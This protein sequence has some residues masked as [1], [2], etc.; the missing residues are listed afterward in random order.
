M[1]LTWEDFD[2]KLVFALRL[3]LFYLDSRQVVK[4]H[5]WTVRLSNENI[6]TVLSILVNVLNDRFFEHVVRRVFISDNLFN[7]SSKIL[8]IIQ[9]VLFHLVF[10][11]G[12]CALSL[13][14]ARFRSVVSVLRI[15]S[16][17]YDLVALL[18]GCLI[19]HLFDD[20]Q[21]LRTLFYGIC[22]LA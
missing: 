3:N 14:H 8:V 7:L 22:D 11:Y 10:D 2:I 17:L 6:D 21:L 13:L 9:L 19:S 4:L 18:T 5:S 15:L 20:A 12:K 16:L 1:R